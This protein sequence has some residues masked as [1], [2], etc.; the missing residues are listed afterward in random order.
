MLAAIHPNS[1]VLSHDWAIPHKPVDKRAHKTLRAAIPDAGG[2]PMLTRWL[3]NTVDLSGG[4]TPETRLRRIAQSIL[5]LAE[6]DDT[7]LLNFGRLELAKSQ[8]AQLAGYRHH[9]LGAQQLGSENWIQY[10][11]RGH[12]EVFAALQEEPELAQL[13]DS[14]NK[15]E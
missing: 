7:E 15:E 11:Q 2:V 3:G 10:L 4:I 14:G 13:L 5:E 6:L 9:L 1:V 12:Q 8:A